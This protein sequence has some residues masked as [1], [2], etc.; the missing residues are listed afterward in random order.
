M[1][2]FE[3]ITDNG[4]GGLSC[5]V[6]EMAKECNGCVVEL[7]KVPLKYAGMQ[8]WQTWI[9]ESQERMTLA[10][11]KEK[12]SEFLALM[13]KRGVEATAIGEFTDSG[14]CIVKSNGKEIMNID[15][16]FLH[17][18]LPKKKLSTKEILQEFSEPIFEEPNI[19]IAL[20][21][22]LSRLNI[23]SREFVSAQYDFEV[24]GNSVLKPL[25]GKG[26]VNAE[27]SAVRPVQELKN[28][29][30]VSQA[31]YPAYG[32]IDTYWMDHQLLMD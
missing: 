8:P 7:E 17:D 24:Q 18:G 19:G 27:A 16:E 25:Q 26:K 11:P 20:K 29:L 9:S 2:L 3:S 14:K 4:A 10:I 31:L 23:C 32:D 1:E 28:A 22:M 12:V 21:E 30:G 6:A 13:E 5:S 15:L